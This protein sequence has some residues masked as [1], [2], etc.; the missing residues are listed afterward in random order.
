MSNCADAEGGSGTFQLRAEGRAFVAILPTGESQLHQFTSIELLVQLGEKCRRDAFFAEECAIGH[1]LAET[2]EP[3]FL[4][5]GEGKGS[6]SHLIKP[7][8]DTDEHR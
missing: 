6:E 3:S 8:M 4:R 5:T 7:Q 2:A 1:R